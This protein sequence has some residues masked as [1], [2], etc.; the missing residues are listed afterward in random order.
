[1]SEYQL[2]LV[3]DPLE[4]AL[5]TPQPSFE[6][7]P[8]PT[9][10]NS[11]YRQ[12]TQHP[13]DKEGPNGI[14]FITDKI[15][16]DIIRA[17][18]GVEPSGSYHW[19]NEVAWQPLMALEKKGIKPVFL[20][21]T[22]HAYLNNK[23]DWNQIDE[24]S[25]NL[26]KVIKR[27]FIDPDIIDGR[28]FQLRTQPYRP[29]SK[30]ELFRKADSENRY[31]EIFLDVLNISEKD[32]KDSTSGILSA[33]AEVQTKAIHYAAMQVADIRYLWEKKN[34]KFVI[35]GIDQRKIHK[36]VW[37]YFGGFRWEKPIVIHSPILISL[38]GEV[39]QRGTYS[40]NERFQ[41]E[42]KVTK[43]SKSIGEKYTLFLDD[44]AEDV[45]KK[46]RIA[47]CPPYSPESVRVGDVEKRPLEDNPVAE[48]LRLVINPHLKT[49]KV[50]RELSRGGDVEA[51]PMEIREMYKKD[52][53]L[54]RELKFAV[55][56]AMVELN[57]QLN[58][59][60]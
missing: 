29:D 26:S 3:R 15:P 50:E 54:P 51:P 37:D 11:L 24:Y 9:P 21:A 8:D 46:L 42:R 16:R 47:A 60:K 23:G 57:R 30:E 12:L 27:L 10:E 55:G 44:S 48:L 33:S 19:G 31:Q 53:F 25:D 7:V 34:V 40:I 58:L 39:R 56:E 38:K 43:M 49:L 22:V 6:I 41:A 1:M 18:E 45:R 36:L 17:Y 4:E 5:H 59:Q 35:G 52:E 28:D 2:K 13:V 14:H 20:S 32:L